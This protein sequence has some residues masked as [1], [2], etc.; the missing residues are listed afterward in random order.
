MRRWRGASRAQSTNPAKRRSQR[1]GTARRLPPWT[2]CS[3]TFLSTGTTITWWWLTPLRLSRGSR[4][5]AALQRRHRSS[6]HCGTSSPNTAS[7]LHSGQME[8]PST[9]PENSSTSATRPRST[10][11]CPLTGTPSPMG[12][13]SRWW[14]RSRSLCA[15]STRKT[16]PTPGFCSSGPFLCCARHHWRMDSLARSG[17]TVRA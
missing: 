14:Q 15:R 4:D 7:L 13:R 1:C 3:R 8:G 17:F 11:A 16:E 10:T 6:A 5:S 12:W 2:S 9:P